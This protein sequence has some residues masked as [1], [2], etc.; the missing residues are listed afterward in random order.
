MGDPLITTSTVSRFLFDSPTR[1]K[2]DEGWFNVRG[3]SAR[4]ETLREAGVRN[5]LV[6]LAFPFQ[7]CL[8]R[9]NRALPLLSEGYDAVWGKASWN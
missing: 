8:R 2:C 6:I 9:Q 5:C 3:T 7:E 4:I 1:P